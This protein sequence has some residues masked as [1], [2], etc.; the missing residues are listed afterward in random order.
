[1][2]DTPN[3]GLPY[4]D[5]GQAQKHVTHNEAL[6]M[7][8]AAIQ[9]A[10]LDRTRMAP[11]ASPTEGQRHVVAAGASE[12]WAGHAHAIATWQDGAWAFLAPKAGWCI[13]SIADDVML[14]FDG[15][16]WRDLR[17]LALDNAAHLGVN[18]AADATNRLSVKSDA[19]LLSHDDVTP[20]SGDVRMVLNKALA[21]RDAGLAFQTGFSARALLGLLGDDN[22]A[23]KVSADGTVFRPALTIDR[24]NGQASLMQSPKFSAYMN[25]DKYCAANTPTKVQ[26]N[27]GR[28][29]D[30]SV[31]DAA[32]SQFVAPA[33]GYYFIG[34]RVLF[35]ANA[36]LPVSMIATLYR[37]GSELIDD[38]RMQTST[39][40]VSNKTSLSANTVLKL[41]AGDTIAVWAVLETNDG[42][43]AAAQNSFYGHRI[44]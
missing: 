33:A 10:V 8:D 38:A 29:N 18:T 1:M 28:H 5:G 11:P 43:I 14:V 25:F 17:N 42:Y 44:P 34:Y 19:V 37:N 12:A 7:L 9:I 4:I 40:L 32:N 15:A 16:A 26:F 41:A 21:A 27:N 39:A 13:W 23:I 20:G 30:F 2:T 31:F 24:S 36:A 6:R 3:L 35:K 22:L